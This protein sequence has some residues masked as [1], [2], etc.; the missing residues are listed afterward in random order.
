MRKH[1]TREREES[2]GS[3]GSMLI[4]R[5]RVEMELIG[6]SNFLLYAYVNHFSREIRI[7]RQFSGNGYTFRSEGNFVS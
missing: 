3:G 7:A 1:K 5:L 6:I 4:Y 2:S